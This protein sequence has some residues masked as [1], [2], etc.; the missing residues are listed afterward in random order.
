MVRNIW[1]YTEPYQEHKLVGGL[2]TNLHFMYL[3]QNCF[4]LPKIQTNLPC[5]LLQF[6]CQLPDRPTRSFIQFG[7]HKKLSK[8]TQ[9]CGENTRD[10]VTQAFQIYA[11][12]MGQWI[13]G[14]NPGP[15]IAP[16]QHCCVSCCFVISVNVWALSS[17]PAS[18]LR[19]PG[20]RSLVPAWECG[21]RDT[22]AP[23]KLGWCIG[24]S[25]RAELDGGPS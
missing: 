7:S 11:S 6:E 3:R 2:Q 16:A 20:W 1:L 12:F 9:T 5:C 18:G 17:T 21:R 25:G 24:C 23:P 14:H 8:D 13:W 10:F 4:S 15:Y 19:F 22:F